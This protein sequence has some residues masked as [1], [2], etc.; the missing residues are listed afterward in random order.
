MNSRIVKAWMVLFLLISG[1]SSVNS[2]IGEPTHV[3]GTSN[4]YPQAEISPSS[5]S[6]VVTSNPSPTTTGTASLPSCPDRIVIFYSRDSENSQSLYAI[7]S[8]GTGLTSLPLGSKEILINER[9][10][11]VSVSEDRHQLI[12]DDSPSGVLFED[13]SLNIVSLTS[14]PDQHYVAFGSVYNVDGYLYF[15]LSALHVETRTLSANLI[16]ENSEPLPVDQ[17][18]E[19]IGWSPV[20]NQ[21]L[22]FSGQLPLRLVDVIC[23][24]T[25]HLCAVRNLRRLSDDFSTKIPFNAWSPD[26]TKIAYAYY[27][28]SPDANGISVYDGLAILNADGGAVI[29][30]FKET[31]LNALN[32]DEIRWSPDGIHLVFTAFEPDR[33]DSDIFVLNISDGSVINLTVNLASNESSP[34]WLP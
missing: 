25:T 33:T 10:M 7:C 11:R 2:T 22:L 4:P 30:D 8:D 6:A 1:C 23:D 31:E 32:I 13:K 21:L 16:P 18:Y 29:A 12:L 14:S 28:V 3:S 9:S 19:W 26:G 5:A 17:G 15:R 24:D 20:G 27:H 34:L